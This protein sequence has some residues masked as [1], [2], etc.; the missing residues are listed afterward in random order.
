LKS[1]GK[2]TGL[3][4]ANDQAAAEASVQVNGLPHVK[5]TAPNLQPNNHEGSMMNKSMTRDGMLAGSEDSSGSSVQDEVPMPVLEYYSLASGDR[6]D[7]PS[8]VVIL[9]AYSILDEDDDDDQFSLP[10]SSVSYLAKILFI[11]LLYEFNWLIYIFQLIFFGVKAQLSNGDFFACCLPS[12][13]R[14]FALSRRESKLDATPTNDDFL[15]IN[16]SVIIHY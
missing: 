13:S 3:R 11:S 2:G 12:A 5:V 15:N 16:Q 8:P 10:P 6:D 14:T 1:K 9:H 7:S 4:I